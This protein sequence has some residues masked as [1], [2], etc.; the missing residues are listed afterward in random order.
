MTEERAG[1]AFLLATATLLFLFFLECPHALLAEGSAAV[2]SE[3]AIEIMQSLTLE[4][5]SF[6]ARMRISNGL[7]NFSVEDLL[8]QLVFS[9]DSGNEV[10]WS[11][12]PDS[13]TAMFFARTDSVVGTD[14]ID[15]T[16]VVLP[17]QTAEIGWVVI[18]AADTGGSNPDGAIYRVGATVSYRIGEEHHLME[19][20]PASIRVK[21]MPRIQMDFFLP[22][23]VSGDDP[24]TPELEPP[25]P[26]SL[27][28]VIGNY[29]SGDAGNLHVDAGQP[30]IVAN[31]T[32]LLVGFSVDKLEV[33]GSDQGNAL[34]AVV[35]LLKA[36]E[37]AS[38]RWI[39]TSSLS[40]SFT[41][42][43][44]SVSHSDELGGEL[45]ALIDESDVRMHELVHTVL[46]D[47]PGRDSVVDFLASGGI[48]YTSEGTREAVGIVDA[49]LSAP[50]EEGRCTLSVSQSTNA[51]F[52][53]NCSFPDGDD[54]TVGTVRRSDGKIISDENVWLSRAKEDGQWTWLLNLFDE[55]SIDCVYEVTVMGEDANE[56]PTLYPIGSKEVMTNQWLRFDVLAVDPDG[57]QTSVNSGDLPAGAIFSGRDDG[58]G[59]FAWCPTV[60]Q[61]GDYS[62]RFQ[63]CDG[64]LSDYENVRI[65]VR[66]EIEKAPGAMFLFK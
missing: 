47:S 3:A 37:S 60:G 17:G 12:N 6:D 7:E 30:E 19:I 14:G 9:D 41:N 65:S 43:G 11:D 21:P 22:G 50:T 29:G 49:A 24:L 48:V 34:T 1:Y 25:V 55:S 59:E 66:E 23:D 2:C 53:A 33:N 32:G 46:L 35:D 54:A 62:V 16:G 26:F 10:A 5:Q 4:R 36:G 63:A 28:L 51:F 20:S 58:R 38:A 40:G 31:E 15:G 56:T 45:T 44:V 8:V 64:I 52:Y 13:S 18:P 39:M 42:L 27:G 57:D 61:I